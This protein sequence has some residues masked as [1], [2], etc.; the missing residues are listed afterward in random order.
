MKKKVVSTEER[1]HYLSN[2]EGE[3]ID[4]LNTYT[5]KISTT[6]TEPRYVKLYLDDISKIQ[7]L[8]NNQNS[9]LL[10]ILQLTSFNTN[11]VILN[12]Y[13][14]EKIAQNINTTDQVI[15]NAISN[16]V[17]REILFKI[18]T[19]VYKL[20]PFLFGS[21]SWQNIKGLRMTIE[22]TND[23]KKIKL[24]ELDENEIAAGLQNAL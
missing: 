5:T 2:F 17:K 7:G 3:V 24:E 15:R 6:E 14:R 23:G 1:I 19:G 9:I 16:L 11:E 8:T 13:N 20:N 18:A 21:G 4:Q 12:K 22:Y 10:G